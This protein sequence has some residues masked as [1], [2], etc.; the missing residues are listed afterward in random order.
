VRPLGVVHW[1]QPDRVLAGVGD[2]DAPG[3]VRAA[4]GRGGQLADQRG[5]EGPEPV[6]FAG[7][8]AQP[9]QGD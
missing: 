9:E 7:P 3:A 2:G 8:L 4:G 1:C 5:V 6:S